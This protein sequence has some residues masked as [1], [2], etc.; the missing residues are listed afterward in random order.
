MCPSSISH[1][2]HRQDPQHNNGSAILETIRIPQQQQQH[3]YDSPQLPSPP[4]PRSERP[5]ASA[6]DVLKWITRKKA[7]SEEDLPGIEWLK[8]LD[9]RDQVCPRLMSYIS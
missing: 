8:R 7:G 3:I 9:G 1:L 4:V 6:Q 2:H 5:K